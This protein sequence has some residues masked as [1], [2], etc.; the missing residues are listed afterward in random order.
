MREHLPL[1]LQL[2][3]VG[4]LGIL[5]AS[6]LVPFRLNW[7]EVFVGLPKLHR[8]MYWVYGGYVVLSIVFLGTVSLIH[9]HELAAGTGLAR[10]VCGYGLVFWLVRLGLQPV[11]DVKEFLTAWW[12]TAGYHLLTVLF[13][14]FTVVYAIATFA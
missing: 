9:A 1:L 4:Q 12:L 14:A 10:W 3:G 7:K 8:Q 13:V 5:F 2:A 11:F 6:A